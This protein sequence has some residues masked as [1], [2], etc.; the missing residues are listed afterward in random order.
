VTVDID[1]FP[2]DELFAVFRVLRTALNPFGPLDASERT[3]LDTFSRITGHRWSPG[4]MPIRPE[5]IHIQGAHARKRM[6]QLASIAAL[7]HGPVR[8]ESARFVK[9]VGKA[10][11]VSDP[12]VPVLEALAAGRKMKARLFTMQRMMRAMIKEAWAAEGA[13]GVARFLAGFFF[14]AVTNKDRLSSYKKLGLLPEGTLG[15]EF[16]KHMTVRGFGFPGEPGGIPRSVAYHDVAHV[17]TGYDTDPRGEIQQGCFQGGN[18]REDGFFFIQFAI[19]QFHQ[20]VKLTPIAK[21]EVGYFDPARVLWAI[22]RGASCRVDVTHRWDYW[23]LLMLPLAEAR[24][25]I[26]LIPGIE[27]WQKAA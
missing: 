10:L 6:L 5:E 15:R 18:R 14:R 3:F 22:H 24:G 19:L 26:A 13:P 4:L 20:G 27:A 2:A 11:G 17:L 16:W 23:P 1:V 8:P 7:F 21:A 12:V 9:E 25:E